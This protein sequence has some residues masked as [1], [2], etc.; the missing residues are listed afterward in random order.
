MKKLD[1]LIE[2]HNKAIDL[3]AKWLP[4]VALILMVVIWGVYIY[5]TK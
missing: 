1:D 2:K 3:L 4:I 5:T